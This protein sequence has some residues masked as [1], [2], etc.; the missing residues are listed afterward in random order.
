MP[1]TKLK[2]RFWKPLL[3]LSRVV[4]AFESLREREQAQKRYQ[5]HT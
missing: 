5:S 1:I 3:P 4:T 2:E